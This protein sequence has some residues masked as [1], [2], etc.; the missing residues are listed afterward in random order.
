MKIVLLVSHPT[1]QHAHK[2]RCNAPCW[3]L[4]LAKISSPFIYWRSRDAYVL[5][6]KLRQPSTMLELL[7]GDEPRI[8]AHIHSP[9][10]P[11][12]SWTII[13]HFTKYTRSQFQKI[14]KPIPPIQ[15]EPKCQ[16]RRHPPPLA[17]LEFSIA[18][19][20]VVKATSQYQANSDPPHHLPSKNRRRYWWNK[21]SPENTY[22]LLS[23]SLPFNFPLL[24]FNLKTEGLWLTSDLGK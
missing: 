14:V 10:L 22:S 24:E 6:T 3:G 20:T 7:E 16:P 17:L 23:L 8:A 11:S 18:L 19:G 12:I 1:R 9:A 21:W 13:S 4:Q 15:I 5:T 2:L